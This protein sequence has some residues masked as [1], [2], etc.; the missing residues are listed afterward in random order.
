MID[1]QADAFLTRINTPQ[2][3][4]PH[5]RQ[6][7]AS[8]VRSFL[9]FLRDAQGSEPTLEDFTAKMVQAYMDHQRHLGLQS[10]T[11]NR[12]L[13]SLRRFSRYLVTE[14]LIRQ[15]PTRNVTTSLE[16][17]EAPGSTTVLSEEEIQHLEAT[18]A[19]KPNARSWRD[20]SIMAL[21]LETG[22]T[23]GRLIAVNL[24]NYDM[25]GAKIFLQDAA[26]DSLQIDI[27]DCAASLRIYLQKGRP[28]LASPNAAALFVSQRGGRMSRQI[29][30][31][32][33]RK[34][35]Q[36]ARLEKEVS[37]RAIRHTAVHRML[38][39]GRSTVEIMNLLG[40]RNR[41]STE[42]LIR[43]VRAAKK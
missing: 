31:H 29:V 34:W 15:D 17:R 19:L 32:M 5:T 40:H 8:D 21:L 22:F 39:S 36:Q 13:V 25:R 6:A 20:R 28:E 10:S 16:A 12:R 18:M 23:T 38:K 35:G 14:G 43:R 37:P 7:Y 24:G 33:L 11:L 3:Y 27:L 9:L 2:Q 41:H 30:W 1:V 4:S 26:G 42:A